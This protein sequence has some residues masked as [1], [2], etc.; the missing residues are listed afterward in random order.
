MRSRRRDDRNN[1]SAPGP[2]ERLGPRL[3]DLRFLRETTQLSLAEAMDIGQTAL[4]HLE[5]RNDILLSS[6]VSYVKAL[7]GC[8][9]IAATFPNGGQF[10]LLGNAEWVPTIAAA[11]DTA[12]D[13]LS[14]PSILGPEHWPPF[15]DVVFSIRPA[16]ASKIFSMAPRL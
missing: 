15:R 6:M 13:Q 1:K 3:R 7:G 14:L 8:L 11:S 4:S 10:K 12:N 2:S 5:H 9:H 16:H